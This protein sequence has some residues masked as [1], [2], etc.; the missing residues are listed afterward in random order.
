MVQVIIIPHHD[1]VSA[2]LLDA[3]IPQV[4]Q[5]Q[6]MIDQKERFETEVPWAKTQLTQLLKVL[7]GTD[8]PGIIPL[9]RLN[10]VD[11]YMLNLVQF[12]L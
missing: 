9:L 7:L 11:N 1:V 10:V 3:A 2:T 12:I 8:I 4:T 6:A 5:G